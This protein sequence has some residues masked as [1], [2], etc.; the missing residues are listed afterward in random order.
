VDS[1][2]LLDGEEFRSHFID[3]INST[4]NTLNNNTENGQTQSSSSSSGTSN[5]TRTSLISI[6]KMDDI[7][8]TLED[9]PEMS[10][11]FTL[12]GCEKTHIMNRKVNNRYG[13]VF[14]IAIT[15]NL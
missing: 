5:G 4:I 8:D 9:V 13:S 12:L 10:V 2:P 7:Y 3:L 1:V 6:V 11:L 14:H 15:G